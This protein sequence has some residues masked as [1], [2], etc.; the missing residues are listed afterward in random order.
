[1]EWNEA[2]KAWDTKSDGNLV[3][4]RGYIQV[5]NASQGSTGTVNF[6]GLTNSGTIAVVVS[7]TE[8]GLSRGFNLV[9]NPYPSY[10]NWSNVIADSENA[11]AGISSSF[12][13]RTKNTLGAYVFTTYNG[14]SNE[15]VGGT[16]ANTAINHL[17]PPMQAFWIKVNANA[18]NTTHSTTLKFKN[19]MRE[20]GLG[21]NNKFK[22]PKANER[23]RL[24]LKLEN[25]AASDETLIYFD[26]QASDYFDNY[27]SP[28]LMNNS[29]IVP[30]LYSKAGAERLVINGL[31]ELRDNLELPLGFSLNA[32]AALKLH[33]SEITHLPAGTNIYL[34]D[35]VENTQTELVENTSYSFTTSGAT[36]NNESRFSLH[37]RAPGATTGMDN[38]DIANTRIFVNAA[39][40]ITIVAPEKSAYSIYN[41]VGMLME[42]G[43]VESGFETRNPKLIP[44]VYVVKVNNSST[45]VIIK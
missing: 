17:I 42:H 10:I 33:V 16:T 4:G 26:A 9:G 40:Q 1:V 27:D 5:A 6:S 25:G 7:R 14:T 19:T 23:L 28:K 31:K 30:D 44:G 29:T 37:F 24:R 43:I 38:A 18:G 11:E 15:V 13:Y 3:A 36:S 45:R 20:H 2:T 8:S 12:W 34:L 21:D 41:A 22:A 35:K 32:A 39:N